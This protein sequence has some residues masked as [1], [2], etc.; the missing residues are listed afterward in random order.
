MLDNMLRRRHRS[1][2]S[3]ASALGPE[4]SSGNRRRTGEAVFLQQTKEVSV[5][6]WGSLFV[7]PEK[8]QAKANSAFRL[9]NIYADA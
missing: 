4:G 2:K 8:H 1:V 3:V 5:A 9:K 7:V 6:N